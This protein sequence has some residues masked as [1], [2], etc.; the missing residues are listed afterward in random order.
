[1]TPERRK[2]VRSGPEE[3][4]REGGGGE[5]AREGTN[6]RGKTKVQQPKVK[7][8]AVL[9]NMSDGELKR[10]ESRDTLRASYWKIEVGLAARARMRVGGGR[11]K[12]SVCL[13]TGV[14]EAFPPQ[15]QRMVLF[16]WSGLGGVLRLR[17]RR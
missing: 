10:V 14:H 1:M 3:V 11:D 12:G 2:G 16:W 4:E 6:K 8:A 17:N 7:K 9:T 13:E 5:G 15:S